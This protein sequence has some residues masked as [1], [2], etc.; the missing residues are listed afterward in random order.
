M[1]K[2]ERAQEL[3]KELN[4]DGWLIISDERSDV[5]SHFLLG[6]EAPSL[7]YIYIAANGDHRILAVEME[8]P[9]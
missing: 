3:I 9:M 1:N 7:N 8:A 4:A 5:H 2:F 6:V